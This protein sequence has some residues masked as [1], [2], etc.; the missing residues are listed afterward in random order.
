MIEPSERPHDPMRCKP[1]HL[2]AMRAE[3]SIVLFIRSLAKA[4]TA[5]RAEAS[6]YPNLFQIME[7]F[8]RNRLGCVKE[9]SA[10]SN[11]CSHKTE[12]CSIAN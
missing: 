5:Y 2:G 8:V 1:P 6:L 12:Q 7:E 3:I 9:N 10:Q 11:K 4:L